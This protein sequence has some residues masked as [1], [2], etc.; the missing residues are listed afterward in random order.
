MTKVKFTLRHTG[1]CT[2]NRAHT[3]RGVPNQ[4]IRFYATI[5]II[6]HPEHGVIVFDT[7]YSNRFFEATRQYP[8]KLYA[9]I[10]KVFHQDG[11]DITSVLKREGIEIDEVRYV[12]ISHFHGD[13]TCGLR[14]FRNAQ[15]IAP[16]RAWNDVRGKQ[17]IAA[18]IKGYLSAT[19]PDDFRDHLRL[20]DFEHPTEVDSILGPMVDVF[21]DGSIRLMELDGHACG[22]MGALLNTQPDPTFLIADAAWLEE[23]YTQLHLP[24]PL[25]RL[26]FSSWKAFVQSLQKVH[27][28][29]LA[30]PE[31]QIIPCHCEKTLRKQS[32]E[33]FHD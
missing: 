8:M 5:G 16:K 3:L 22:Q 13:H 6:R 12:L 33:L 30:H 23:N 28:Y 4:T 7:G 2:A 14:D 1:Y 29:H 18:L 26:I 15:F 9:Q 10:T 27:A 20:I 11:E 17:G 21:S 24:A 31:V 32:P 19:I 25:T